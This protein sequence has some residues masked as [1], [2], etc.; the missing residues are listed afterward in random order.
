[1]CLINGDSGEEKLELAAATAAQQLSMGRQGPL[2]LKVW[3]Q[4]V[5]V[6]E[7]PACASALCSFI[8]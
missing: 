2:P 8:A 6:A 7:G 5:R 1:M 3:R 4:L